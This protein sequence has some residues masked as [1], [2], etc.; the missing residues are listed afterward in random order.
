[1]AKNYIEMKHLQEIESNENIHTVF[2][3]F[4]DTIVHRTVH[5]NQVFRIWAKLIIREFG[6]TLKVDELYFIRQDASQLLARKYESLNFLVDYNELITE[7]Y[8]RLTATSELKNISKTD[9]KTYFE[10]ADLRAEINVQYLNKKAIDLFK[11]LKAQEYKIYVVSDFYTSSKIIVNLL[12]HH[13]IRDLLDGVFVS[14][15]YAK[16]KHS[17]DFYPFLLKELGLKAKN[18]VMVGDNYRSDIENAKKH[19]LSTLY[20]P[21]KSDSKTKKK[22]LLGSDRSDYHKVIKKLYQECHATSAPAN[23][24]FILYYAVY[25]ERLY[26]H[27]KKRGIFNILFLSREGLFLKKLFDHYQMHIALRSEDIIKTHYFKTSRQASML[28]AFEE[29]DNE[30]YTFLRRK[31]PNLSPVNFLRN[32][33]FSEDLIAQIIDDL[34]LH[35]IANKVIFDFLDSEVYQKIKSNDRFRNAYDKTRFNQKMAFKKYLDSFGIDFEEEGMHLADI[36]WGG[37][38]QENLYDYFDGRVEVH[39]HYLGLTEIYSI[40]KEK[41]RWGLNFSVYPYATYHDNILRGNTEL[42][43]Q[44]LSAGHGSTLSYNLENTFANEFHH[45]VEKRVYDEHISV[46]QKFMFEKFKVLLEEL[47]SICY[48]DEIVQNEM[49]DYA[50]RSGLFASKRKI[51]SAI[52]ISKGFYSNVGDFSNGMQMSPEKYSGDKFNL[53]KTFVLNPDVLFSALLRIKPYLYIK[54]KYYLA[55]LMPSWLIYHYIK[56][57]R[58]VKKNIFQKISRFKFTYLK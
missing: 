32:F 23:S 31:Y 22:F 48:D 50:L 6:L 46:I 51:V 14:A 45:E 42:N 58:L 13:Q 57:N 33:T 3:D 44:L 4:F 49:T 34:N 36:G 15:D 9:F 38:M 40:D 37:S 16:S 28:V 52:N 56:T 5:P 25:I 20:I 55:Y 11:D 12:D 53:L 10:L 41:A 29:V 17:G 26:Q 24:D 19:G 8:N 7:V 1:M 39:G 21:N 2:V 47:D 30:K 54:N 27:L 18:V 35:D 43:E